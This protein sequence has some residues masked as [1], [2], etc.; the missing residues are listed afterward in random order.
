MKWPIAN[1][2]ST[3]RGEAT[4]TSVRLLVATY[5][6]FRLFFKPR[7]SF[8][9]MFIDHTRIYGGLGIVTRDWVH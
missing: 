1:N 2:V 7:V 5:L 6:L 9:L 4:N 8:Y 3:H